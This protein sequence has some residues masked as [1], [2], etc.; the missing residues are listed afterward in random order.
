MNISK[1]D[2][3]KLKFNGY[4]NDLT[5]TKATNGCLNLNCNIRT[6]FNLALNVPA[7]TNWKAKIEQ[8]T[9][10]N[11]ASF[12]SQVRTMCRST[13][14]IRT[15]KIC[16]RKMRA[17]EWQ[18]HWFLQQEAVANFANPFSS[19]GTHKVKPLQNFRNVLIHTKINFT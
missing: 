13:K 1:G 15:S 18:T 14:T 12:K 7:S 3:I 8:L 17:K 10:K 16:P 4:M 11:N 5:P 6:K 9:F 19:A 2:L